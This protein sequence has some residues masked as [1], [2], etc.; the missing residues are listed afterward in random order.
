M[1][2]PPPEDLGVDT[3]AG[4]SGNA[5]GAPTNWAWWAALA[6]LAAGAIAVLY[7]LFAAASKPEQTAGLTRFAH[8]HMRA[9]AVLE[10]PP[11]M[12]TRALRDAAGAETT[13]AA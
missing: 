8:G 2:W 1:R 3:N 7:V 4:S 5:P 13:L 9:L 12:P 10:A 6:M 11:P